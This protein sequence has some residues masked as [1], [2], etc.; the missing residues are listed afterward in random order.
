MFKPRYYIENIYELVGRDDLT[1]A[2]VFF[3][4]SK[5]HNLYGENLTVQFLYNQ[6]ERLNLDDKI[7]D[8]NSK[9]VGYVKAKY[10]GYELADD[11]VKNLN[12]VGI[13]CEDIASL[14]T[15]VGFEKNTFHSEE[16]RKIKTINIPMHSQPKGGDFDWMYG[17]TKRQINDGIGVS[18]RERNF[19]LAGKLYYEPDN[20]SGEER[21]EMFE[22]NIPKEQIEWEYLT[23]KYHREDITVVENERLVEL[24]YKKKQNYKVL[25]ENHLNESG[26]SINKLSKENIELYED[27]LERVMHFKERRLNVGGKYAIFL[28]LDSYLHIFMRHVEEM[29]VNKHFSHKDNFQWNLDDVMTVIKHVIHEIE[30]QIQEFFE[31]N[32]G[33]Q[34][35]IYGE[36][37][38]YYQGDYYAVYI[39]PN[40]RL[41]SLFKIKKQL[42]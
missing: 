41:E 36:H 21:L 17:F 25:L 37:A 23:I 10:L 26:S 39:D 32:K 24:Y 38:V 34:F 42:K 2:L 28:D 20:L 4:G 11:L 12:D 15:I 1:A 31:N 8:K 30:N 22:N 33:K 9:T 5:S 35:R 14:Y 16:K 3:N 19:Y 6:K 27:L 13:Y 18:P 7:K 29:K 40:G